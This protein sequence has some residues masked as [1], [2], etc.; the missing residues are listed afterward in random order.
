MSERASTKSPVGVLLTAVPWGRAAWPMA[1]T[2][3][4]IA[5]AHAV[6]LESVCSKNE[7]MFVVDGLTSTLGWA[8]S[9]RRALRSL[10]LTFAS[11]AHRPRASAAGVDGCIAGASSARVRIPSPRYIG[12]YIVREDP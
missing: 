11:Q 5:A 3:G 9:A 4:A 7:S 6:Q 1:R 10:A 12:H 2:E 8:V